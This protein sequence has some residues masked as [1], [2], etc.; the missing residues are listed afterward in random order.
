MDAPD[1]RPGDVDVRCVGGE[2][3]GYGY[4]CPGCGARDYLTL[5][6]PPAPT[7]GWTVTGGDALRPEGVTLAPSV[8]HACGWHGWLRAGV[9]EPA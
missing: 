8:L 4:V 1:A 7:E 6:P 3:Y 5:G 9:W 2:L